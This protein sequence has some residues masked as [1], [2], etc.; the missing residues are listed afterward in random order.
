MLE[1]IRSDKASKGGNM[2]LEIT[3]RNKY[4]VSSRLKQIIEDKMKKLDKYFD[5]DASAKIVC[6]KNGKQEKLEGRRR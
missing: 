2:K 6:S 1:Y 4:K 5:K 3:E